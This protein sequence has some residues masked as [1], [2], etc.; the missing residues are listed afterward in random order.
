MHNGKADGVG[1]D[2]QHKWQP[3]GVCQNLLNVS[4][5]VEHPI[6]RKLTLDDFPETLGIKLR[7]LGHQWPDLRSGF[8]QVQHV[9][10]SV[11]TAKCHG[12]TGRG[13]QVDQNK[14]FG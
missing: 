11:V 9:V 10:F 1:F 6:G 13:H 5:G 4:D 12:P 2:P 8:H 14:S 7:H 3:R